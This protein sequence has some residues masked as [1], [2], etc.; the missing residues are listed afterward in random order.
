MKA[1]RYEGARTLAYTEVADPSPLPGET[2]VKVESVGICGSDMHAFLGHDERRPP[3]LILGHEAAGV[4]AEGRRVTV[5]PLASCGRCAHCQAGR[6]NLCRQ[7]QILSMPPRQGAFAEY[8]TVPRENLTVVPDEIPFDQA[9]L[10]E[11]LACGWHAVRL[12][13]ERTDG[14]MAGRRGLVI[15]GGAI[16]LGIALALKAQGVESVVI[17]ESNARRHPMLKAAGF[18]IMAAESGDAEMVFDAVGLATTREMACRLVAA[19]G[20]IVHV[21]L[22]DNAGGID[23]RRLTLQEIDFVGAY[24]Y[25]PDDFHATAAALFDGR[26]GTLDWFETRPLRDGAAAFADMLAGGVAAAKIILRPGV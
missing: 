20:V 17:A 3:P 2:W 13:A 23:A 5:N 19:G 22:G 7:R 11:P 25:T 12:A 21:G 1:L 10:A 9:A 4:D 15:G 14:G 24:T 16:G 6:R 18:E 26:L 8:L